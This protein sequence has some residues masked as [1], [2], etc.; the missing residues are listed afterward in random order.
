MPGR[1]EFAAVLRKALLEERPKIVGVELPVTL[2]A[3]YA[4]AVDR[5]PAMSVIVY[6]DQGEEDT[7]VY[8]PVEPSDPFTEALRTAREIGAQVVF[9]DP[10][11]GERPHLGRALSGY[12]RAAIDRARA[13]RRMLPPVSADRVRKKSNGTRMESRGSCRAPIRWRASSSVISLNLLDPVLDAMERPQAQPFSRRRMGCA[14]AE[15]A[16][17]RRWPKLRRTIRGCRSAMKISAWQ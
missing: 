11:A 6:A 15:S 3:A 12:L 2:E 4:R 8:V 10:D 13:I 17:R 1:L 7:A 9:L 16:S 5:L 14:G